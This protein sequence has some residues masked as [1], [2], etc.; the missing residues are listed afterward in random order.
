MIR[1]LADKIKDGGFTCWR[2]NPFVVPS[3]PNTITLLSGVN[4]TVY[5]QFVIWEAS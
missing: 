5:T 2:G 1:V 4:K 3:E